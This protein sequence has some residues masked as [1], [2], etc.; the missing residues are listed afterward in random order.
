MA[1][2]HVPRGASFAYAVAER[3]LDEQLGRIEALDSKAGILIAA[4]GVLSGLLFGR[5]SLLL[6]MPRPLGVLIALLVGSSLLLGLIAF[7]NRRYR[8]APGVESVIRL[9]AFGEDWLR[10][11]FLGSFQLALEE[12]GTKLRWKSRCLTSALSTLIAAVAMLVGYFVFAVLS[13]KG[14]VQS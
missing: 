3:N 6:S 5:S 13:G 10:W 7:G 8:R 1:Q 12:N 2:R 14:G 9:M 11:R 4:D